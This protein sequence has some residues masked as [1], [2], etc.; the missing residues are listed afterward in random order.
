MGRQRV[1]A[2]TP[3]PANNSGLCFPKTNRPASL[4]TLRDGLGRISAC[5]GRV[6]EP[7]SRAGRFVWET[8]L[9]HYKQTSQDGL[10][11]RWQL[12]LP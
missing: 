2:S 3:R 1:N 9:A 12:P 4:Y 11:A 5:S 6:H 10:F 8:G 7:T